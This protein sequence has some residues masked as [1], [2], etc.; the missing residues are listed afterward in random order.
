MR[1]PIL[2]V[3]AA[4]ALTGCA[5]APPSSEPIEFHR[6]DRLLFSEQPSVADL[7]RARQE[8]VDLVISTRRQSEMDRLAFDERAEVERLGMVYAHVP[9]GGD[10]DE[11]DPGYTPLQAQQFGKVLNDYFDGPGRGEHKN[12]G[13]VLIHC[14]SGGRARLAWMAYLIEHEGYTPQQAQEAAEEVGHNPP[15]LERLLG[16]ELELR[17]PDAG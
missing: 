4:L 12:G 2:A 6:A 13:N 9:M 5:S 3:I 14:A 16:R 11:G 8:G 7:E 17:F 10:P 15:A 1:E